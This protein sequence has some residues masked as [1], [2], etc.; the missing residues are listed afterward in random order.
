[1]QYFTDFNYCFQFIAGYL[2][3]YR[4]TLIYVT[5]HIWHIQYKCFLSIIFIFEVPFIFLKFFDSL[6]VLFSYIDN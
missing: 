4:I 5:W 1:V 3:V 2:V 6:C